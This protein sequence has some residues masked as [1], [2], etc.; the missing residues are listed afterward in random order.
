MKKLIKRLWQAF[1]VMLVSISMIM[2]AFSSDA[3]AR[4]N[5]REDEL[6]ESVIKVES[7]ND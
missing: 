5:R 7:G 2:A 4:P 6:S 3:P 1:L